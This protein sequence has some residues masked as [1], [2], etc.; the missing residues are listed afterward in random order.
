MDDAGFLAA[1]RA[2]PDDP[3]PRLVFADWLDDYADPRAALIRA[4]ERLRDLS[5]SSDDYWLLKPER[6]RLKAST[7]PEYLALLGYHLPQPVFSHGWPGEWKGRWRLIRLFAENW[8]GV[9][10]PDVG[11]RRPEVRGVELDL[12][13]DLPES[14]RELHAFTADL[15]DAGR[16][17]PLGPRPSSAPCRSKGRCAGRCPT[18][19]P[20]SIAGASRRATS[21]SPT[22]RSA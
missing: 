5:P 6:D 22:R 10:L 16:P 12:E 15:S 7:D 4:E 3:A 14:L 2:A 1:M 9:T 19:R 20:P 13:R 11:G 18:S 17:P 8:L 21:P